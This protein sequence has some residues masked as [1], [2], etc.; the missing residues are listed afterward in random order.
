MFPSQNNHL[1][2]YL[3]F[4][5]MH[6]YRQSLLTSYMLLIVILYWHKQHDMQKKWNG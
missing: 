4:F 3:D 1:I 2:K 6:T 5:V